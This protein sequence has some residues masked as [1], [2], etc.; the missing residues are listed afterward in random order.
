MRQQPPSFCRHRL[1]LAAPEHNISSDRIRSCIDR[2]GGVGGPVAGVH[3][4]ISKI[5]S[6][7]ALHESR[8]AG[9]RG[10]PSEPE[11]AQHALRRLSGR[12]A[13]ATALFALDGCVLFLLQRGRRFRAR[14]QARDESGLLGSRALSASSSAA[15][16]RP[17]PVPPNSSS[18]P[19]TQKALARISPQFPVGRSAVLRAP[20][21]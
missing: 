6:E 21:L 2:F 16:P 13:A 9:S 8:V 12:L 19:G 1:I 5:V 11:R 20:N 7:T 18:I 17:P 14:D 10:R 4:D 15:S 3:A